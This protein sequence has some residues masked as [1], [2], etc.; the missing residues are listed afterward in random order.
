MRVVAAR[1]IAGLALFIGASAAFA[2][3]QP[4]TDQI[5]VKWRDGSSSN[6]AAASARTQKLGS[7]AGVRWQRKQQIGEATDVLQ[8]ER[9]LDHGE[10]NTLL[11]RMA[12]TLGTLARELWKGDFERMVAEATRKVQHDE[13][14]DPLLAAM[15]MR[16]GVYYYF[17]S[18][19]EGGAD[20]SA[21]PSVGRSK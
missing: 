12:V 10:M 5:I 1:I 4:P 9:A 3:A 7:S 15:R 20:E 21:K 18:M 6:A 11:E 2:Q 14:L 19:R 17:E 8:L 16:F 13:S